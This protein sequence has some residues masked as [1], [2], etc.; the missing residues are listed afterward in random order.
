MVWREAAVA[1]WTV[2]LYWCSIKLRARVAAGQVIPRKVIINPFGMSVESGERLKQCPVGT[3][4]RRSGLLA[5][6]G[7]WCCN[8]G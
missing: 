6:L 7:C 3:G 2:T 8:D 4:S 5:G 1:R